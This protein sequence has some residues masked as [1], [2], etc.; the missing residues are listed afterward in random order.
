MSESGADSGG[1]CSGGTFSMLG[2]GVAR[3][4]A[5]GA[6]GGSE[7]G[8]SAGAALR[9]MRAIR[10]GA[11]TGRILD[12]LDYKTALNGHPHPKRAFGADVHSEPSC[13]LT[14]LVCAPLPRPS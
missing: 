1:G 3:G 6:V 11:V 2:A 8:G 10:T 4:G 14:H 5:G 13:N 9:R 12:G 7:L